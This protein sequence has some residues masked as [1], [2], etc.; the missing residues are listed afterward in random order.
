MDGSLS[1]VERFS[2]SCPGAAYF[3]VRILTSNELADN[4]GN[5]LKKYFQDE[6]GYIAADAEAAGCS[7]NQLNYIYTT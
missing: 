6:E 1:D 3:E 7:F 5:D 4:Y 2:V